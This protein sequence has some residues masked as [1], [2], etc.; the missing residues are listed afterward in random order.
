MYCNNCGKKGHL[1]KECKLPV[2]SCGNI[3]F[4]LDTDEP[5]ILMIQR[6][7]SLCYIDFIRGKYDIKN[8]KYL[9]ILIDKCSIEEKENLI[10]KTFKELWCDLWLVSDYNS[11]NEN[12]D[13]LKSCRKFTVLKEGLYIQSKLISIDYLV[14]HSL[15]NYLT[16]EWEFPK[17]R[18]NLNENDFDCAKREF[19]EETSY[20]DQDYD[21]ITNISPFTEEFVGENRVKYKYIYYIGKLNNCEK[22]PII[23]KMNKEQVTEIKNVEWFTKSES[24]KIIRD[25]HHS[26]YK[27]IDKIYNFINL[28]S[29][30]KYS[31]IS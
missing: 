23:D 19:K 18:R 2:T 13:Y 22:I 14:K 20:L 4:R 10:S 15:T 21:I 5:K 6:K 9:Q 16:S 30:E 27:I 29:D 8:E 12:E 3:V 26:R 7:D 1:Y 11:E 31:L 17:G 28:L 25:Y 24:L